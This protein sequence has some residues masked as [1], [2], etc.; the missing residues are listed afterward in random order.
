MLVVFYSLKH[1]AGATPL[2]SSLCTYNH[3]FS[4]EISSAVQARKFNSTKPKYCFPL[5]CKGTCISFPSIVKLEVRTNHRFNLQVSL[6][7]S[8]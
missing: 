2:L 1:T 4:L 3:S 8:K 6:D 5:K 7:I